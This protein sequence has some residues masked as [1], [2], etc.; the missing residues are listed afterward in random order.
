MANS[1]GT[2]AMLDLLYVLGT[3]AFFGL[4]MAYVRACEALGQGHD[5]ARREP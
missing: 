2:A 4:M 1:P 5:D 3:I